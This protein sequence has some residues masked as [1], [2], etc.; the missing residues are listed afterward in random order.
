MP[1]IAVV[2]VVE[3]SCLVDVV[4]VD[5]GLDGYCCGW[6]GDGTSVSAETLDE[7]TFGVDVSR[8]AVFEIGHVAVDPD[9][10]TSFRQWEYACQRVSAGRDYSYWVFVEGYGPISGEAVRVGH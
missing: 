5:G 7:V 1:D 4:R 9:R 3:D 8:G 6:S 10:T 2:G